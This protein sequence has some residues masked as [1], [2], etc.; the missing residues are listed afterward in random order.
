MPDNNSTKYSI[1]QAFRLA[2]RK[3]AIAL[4]EERHEFDKPKKQKPKK[5]KPEWM[6]LDQ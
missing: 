1:S 4:Q 6:R 2:G 5:Q 3:A